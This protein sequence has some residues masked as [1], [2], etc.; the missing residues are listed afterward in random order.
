MTPTP[1]YVDEHAAAEILG[2]ARGTLS[3]WRSRGEGPTF[4]R[5]GRRAIRYR[6]EDL[7]EFAAGGR[8]ETKGARR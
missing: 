8:V 1:R 2:V 7:V 4:T 3:N 5:I 6:V